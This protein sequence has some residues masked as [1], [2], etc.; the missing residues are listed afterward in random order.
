MSL[1]ILFPEIG[2]S[3]LEE[4][5][6]QSQSLSRLLD[7]AAGLRPVVVRFSP[8]DEAREIAAR[9]GTELVLLVTDSHVVTEASLVAR[10][11]EGLEAS[12]ADFVVPV[13]NEGLEPRQLCHPDPPYLT[14]REFE[15]FARQQTGGAELL[16]WTS[17]DPGIALTRTATLLRRRGPT[18]SV[19][20]GSSVA[21]LGDVYVHRWVT[22]R[23]QDRSDL[24]ALI[25][26]GR[27]SVLDLGCGEG[28][29]G[30]QV[31]SSRGA[32]V[33]GIELEPAAASVAAT[34]LDRVVAGNAEDALLSLGET[35]DCILAGDFLE[36]LFDPWQ[37]LINLK[38]VARPGCKL[39]IAIPNAGHGAIA[40]DLLA[41]RFD[42]LYF[43]LT[44]VGHL[45]F[46]TQHALRSLMD[47]T[48]W[49][50]ESIEPAH[51][52]R[53][54]G[55]ERLAAE[56]RSIGREP[57]PAFF[58]PGFYVICAPAPPQSKGGE[59]VSTP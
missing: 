7:S 32:R 13:T 40:A 29:L 37:F 3:A 58:V 49:R 24:C 25:P 56:L 55:A 10:L 12:G 6:A 43:G 5:F 31:K 59:P 44:C 2:S 57:D 54:S 9:V 41:G 34:R 48:G 17:G 30:S 38:A 42:Y 1:T 21:I 11:V 27:E 8:R 50:I 51:E 45:R 33:V 35:F 19:C 18:S 52:I 23:A 4:R 46:F 14:L 22:L 53:T 36:H 39:I 15:E 20:A 16:S 28:V 47:M 26:P